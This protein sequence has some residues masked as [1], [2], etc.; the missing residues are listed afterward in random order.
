MSLTVT[1]AGICDTVQDLGRRGYQHRGINPG[2][3]MDGWAAQIINLL[4]GNDPGAAVIEMHFPAAAMAFQEDCILVIG[5]ADFT[6]VI[7]GNEVP[8]HQPL[9]VQ[10]GSELQFRSR[11]KGSW[12]YIAVRGG[13][14]VEPWLGSCSTHL[15]AGAGGWQGRVLQKN[16][17]I[18]FRLRQSSSQKHSRGFAIF[19]WGAAAF[20]DPAPSNEI[21]I[22]TGNEWK[23][24][25]EESKQM[26]GESSFT[27]QPSSDRMGYSIKGPALS[28][29]KDE[30][31]VSSAVGFG[32]IQLLPDG[33]LVILMADHQTT[34]GYP[35]IGHVVKAHLPRLA[36]LQ[37]GSNLAFKMISHSTAEQLLLQQYRH[38]KELKNACDFKRP[39]LDNI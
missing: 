14:A 6:P 21:W 32:T 36:Q 3:V 31:L 8:L 33:Q 16:D 10:V 18:H 15:K 7:N 11:K 20:A 4:A 30:Q 35:R 5:G 26:I 2:G 17:T 38:I 1:K 25:N 28:L 27:L 12:C 9:L 29:L 34:G 23:E 37:P 13:F 19:P 39:Q 22:V 24:L